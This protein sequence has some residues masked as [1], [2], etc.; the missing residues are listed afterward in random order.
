MAKKSRTGKRP[1]S[2]ARELG[3]FLLS[4]AVI[5]ALVATGVSLLASSNSSVSVWQPPEGCQVNIEGQVAAVDYE[6][7]I[8]VSVIVGESL[9]RGLPARAATIALTTAYQESN[10]YNLD[11]GDRDSLGLFQQRPSQGWGSEEQ[12]M[13]PWYSAGAF[14]DA[15]VKIQDWQMSDIN[16]TAQEVQRS[17]H[18][19]AYRKHEPNARIWASALTGYSPMSVTCIDRSQNPANPDALTQH[20]TQI[21]GES[22]Q[23]TTDGS[24]LVEV[25]APDET[26][27]WALAQLS[28]LWS[29]DAG[30]T[31]I[32]YGDNSWKLS[33]E[34][35]LPWVSDTTVQPDEVPGKVQIWLR[36]P[37]ADDNTSQP[38]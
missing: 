5:A 37:Q 1:V 12:I 6:Q 2:R 31:A 36:S 27:G 11:Y 22:I 8:N 9:R 15:L 30:I 26:T 17:N 28:Q 18:P 16:D 7:A 19:Q 21:F 10:L 32:R 38:G 29:R 24:Y 35:Y 33:G 3:V 20:L 34:E 25:T 23:I 13:D 4:L 14:Y